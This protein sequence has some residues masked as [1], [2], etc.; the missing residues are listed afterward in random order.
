MCS[1]RP[2]ASRQLVGIFGLM[3]GPC[4]AAFTGGG[5]GI[6]GWAHHSCRRGMVLGRV[7]G[8]EGFVE[9]FNRRASYGSHAVYTCA[10]PRPAIG[11]APLNS[12][13][14]NRF[15]SM[16]ILAIP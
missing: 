3:P 2:G 13:A 9:V 14:W 12:L 10:T 6:R 7:I 16:S 8:W 15:R 1:R 4:S 11:A 5:C